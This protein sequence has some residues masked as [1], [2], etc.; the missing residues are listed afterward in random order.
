MAELGDLVNEVRSIEP[1]KWKLVWDHY[2]AYLENG[3]LV[4]L[5]KSYQSYYSH[6]EGQVG[7]NYYLLSILD[8]KGEKVIF[9]EDEREGKSTI[10]ELYESVEEISKVTKGL[11]LLRRQ[12]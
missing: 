3:I 8:G 7:C 5:R 10:K 2:S 4:N 9:R 1:E 12:K 6:S 11:E